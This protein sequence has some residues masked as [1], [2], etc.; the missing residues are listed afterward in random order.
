MLLENV[1][2]DVQEIIIKKQIDECEN[3]KCTRAQDY[4][5][6]KIIREWSQTA[7]APGNEIIIM[8]GGS[9]QKPEK[10]TFE[11]SDNQVI[12]TAKIPI[13]SPIGAVLNYMRIDNG[14]AG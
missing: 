12:I 7:G 3:C 8:A 2:V 4:A 13:T 1:P 5:I 11:F 6:H 10:F 9:F 14:K